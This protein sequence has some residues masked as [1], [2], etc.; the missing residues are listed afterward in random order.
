MHLV[1][2][3]RRAGAGRRREDLPR[4]GVGREKAFRGV[5]AHFKKIPLRFLSPIPI[6]RWAFLSHLQRRGGK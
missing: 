5:M 1:L 4:V 3:V 2:N 6:R